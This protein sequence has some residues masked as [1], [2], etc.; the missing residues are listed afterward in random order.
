[1]LVRIKYLLFSHPLSQSVF[2]YI[3]WRELFPFIC[4]CL[5]LFL[6]VL[7]YYDVMKLIKC[8]VVSI[9]LLMNYRLFQMAHCCCYCCAPLNNTLGIDYCHIGQLCVCVCVCVCVCRFW[10]WGLVIM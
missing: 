9:R 2:V 7:F 10:G 8:V 3:F 5:A 1:M 6:V 4:L